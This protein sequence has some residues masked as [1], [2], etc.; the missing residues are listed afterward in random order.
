MRIPR[1]S[2]S[3]NC[4]RRGK[5]V[6]GFS[7]V[8]LV[9]V[10]V[11]LGLIAA[12]AVPR[13]TKGSKDAQ[14]NAVLQTLEVVRGAIDHYFAEH[15]KYP[16][17]DPS[18]GAP[19]DTWFINQLTQFSDEAG[20]VS[21]MPTSTH[22]YGPYLREPFPTNP[23]ND[24]SNVRVRATS[25]TAI[26]KNISGWIASLDNGEFVLNTDA[27]NLVRVGITAELANESV[28]FPVD[29]GVGVGVGGT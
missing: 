20:D 3:T 6:D 9:V 4:A 18:N 16:G 8:E 29:L 24:K 11:I 5:P 15:G 23:F 19:A 26:A 25:S 12:I 14:A 13:Y 10:I 21:R 27:E 22:I 7:L 2:Q 28:G 1:P 17:Y